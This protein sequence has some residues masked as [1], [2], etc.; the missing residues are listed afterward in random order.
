MLGSDSDTD[1]SDDEDEDDEEEDGGSVVRRIAQSA[2]VNGTNTEDY[3]LGK[4]PKAMR[5][6]DSG[7]S[8][9]PSSLDDLLDDQPSLRQ[10]MRGDKTSDRGAGSKRGRSD[11][12]ESSRGKRATNG[13]A[14]EKRDE[15]DK[16]N[17]VVTA[18]GRIVVKEV[19]VV[20]EVAPQKVRGKRVAEDANADVD[21][22]AP[23][24]EHKEAG[25]QKRRKLNLKEPGEEYRAKKAGGDVWK[26]GMLEPHAFI[27]LD[28]RLLSKKHRGQAIDH[29]GVVVKGGANKKASALRN[30]GKEKHG[31]KGGERHMRNRP[32]QKKHK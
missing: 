23:K 15:D 25:V 7:R 20:E 13:S 27:P 30:K 17:V 28:P 1:G 26:K 9:L 8:V 21:N 11:V 4:R 6:G 12:D 29:F 5:V 10:T 16:Y 3:R 31:D 18:D 32:H 2:G 22:E 14:A 24:Q 19:E